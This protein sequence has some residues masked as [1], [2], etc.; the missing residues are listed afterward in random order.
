MRFEGLR[1]TTAIIG[2]SAAIAAF[3]APEAQAV[4]VPPGYPPN[5]EM[6]D[7][8]AGFTGVGDP[9][10]AEHFPGSPMGAFEGMYPQIDMATYGGSKDSPADM[11][12][13]KGIRVD[14]YVQLFRDCNNGEKTADN[15]DRLDADYAEVVF[16]VGKD[17]RYAEYI[18]V[19]T[20]LVDSDYPEYDGVYPEFNGQP[21]VHDM[22]PYPVDDCGPVEPFEPMEPLK[23]GANEDDEFLDQAAFDACGPAFDA[24]DL[25]PASSAA[26][27]NNCLKASLKKGSINTYRISGRNAVAVQATSGY[28]K[29]QTS[30]CEGYVYTKT[31]VTALQDTNKKVL[32][33]NSLPKVLKGDEGIIK[34]NRRY[35]CKG[36]ARDNKVR[37]FGVQVTRISNIFDGSKDGKQVSK[38][39]TVKAPKYI[40]KGK[41]SKVLNGC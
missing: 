37:G 21:N 40:T 11:L 25:K 19:D 23:P 28:T 27:V 13:P 7:S 26:F 2:T 3:G 1:T 6:P 14:N 10:I 20:S 34:T 32:Q 31:I 35:T 4:P 15:C 12:N 17:V 29:K 9:V 33:K 36:T 24:R 5:T 38:T 41:R 18:C 22:A 16:P 39:Y 8:C 30:D